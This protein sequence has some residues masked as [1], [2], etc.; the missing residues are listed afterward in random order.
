MVDSQPKS[1][2]DIHASLRVAIGEMFQV[3]TIIVK[4]AT[5]NK[6]LVD[7]ANSLAP[8]LE[9]F[10]GNVANFPTAE[11]MHKFFV[12]LYQ[13]KEQSKKVFYGSVINSVIEGNKDVMDL[14]K[15]GKAII[16]L[17]HFEE[18]SAPLW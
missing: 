5:K 1:K 10:S 13:F 15:I 12:L 2:G 16:G 18:K 7:L 3:V 6:H 14:I 11:A 8:V 9:R 4:S 17:I